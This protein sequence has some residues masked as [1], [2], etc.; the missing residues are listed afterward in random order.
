M[1]F[2][3]MMQ[4]AQKMQKKLQEAQAELA[5][6]EIPGE[7]GNGAVK[8]ICNGQGKFKSIKLSAQA[9]NPDNPSTVDQDTIEMLEDMISQAMLQATEKASAKTEAAM[10]NIT[11]G[12]SIPGLF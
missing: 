7:A 1:N 5:Q 8:V 11:G 6:M 12:I 3:N 4:Q 10:K 9:I 2:A